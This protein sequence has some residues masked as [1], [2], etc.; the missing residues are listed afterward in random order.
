MIF[1]LV[2]IWKVNFKGILFV[3]KIDFYLVM[4]FVISLFS[5]LAPCI[6]IAKIYCKIDM[7]RDKISSQKILLNIYYRYYYISGK[8]LL[9]DLQGA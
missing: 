9:C 1:L 8:K 7:K 2:F 4:S 6:L 5:L 3:I